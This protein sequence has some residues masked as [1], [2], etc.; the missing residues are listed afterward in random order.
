MLQYIFSKIG[1]RNFFCSNPFSAILGLIKKI[2]SATKLEGGGE[3]LSGTAT[4]KIFFSYATSLMAF[5]YQGNIIS[6]FSLFRS[7]AP[8]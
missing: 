8:L 1:D 3:G 5:I 2:P 4:Q 6:I 7:V